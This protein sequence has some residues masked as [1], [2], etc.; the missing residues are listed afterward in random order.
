MCVTIPCF[1]LMESRHIKA[2]PFCSATG[3]LECLFFVCVCKES[4]HACCLLET[5]R[6][7]RISFLGGRNE[8]TQ[9]KI[10]GTLKSWEWNEK[11][12]I[13]WSFSLDERSLPVIWLSCDGEV[14]SHA[15]CG[16]LQTLYSR[17][18]LFSAVTINHRMLWPQNRN[19][20]NGVL[21]TTR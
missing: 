19:S 1:I 2:S 3:N 14:C 10:Y 11:I 5:N 12:R 6:K 21:W 16:D 9:G 18:P 15:L 13:I 4:R 8:C 20:G 7:L 17:S